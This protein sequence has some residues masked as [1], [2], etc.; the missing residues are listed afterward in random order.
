MLVLL[1]FGWT[2]GKALVATS[3]SGAKEKVHRPKHDEPEATARAG[4]RDEAS[5]R[6]QRSDGCGDKRDAWPAQHRESDDDV[7][8]S[9]KGAGL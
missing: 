6:T 5:L 3:Y 9:R 8:R 1:I 4:M 2:G 7:T